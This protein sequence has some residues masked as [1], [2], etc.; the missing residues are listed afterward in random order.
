[1]K[2]IVAMCKKTRGIG[3]RNLLPFN[4]VAD[5]KRF[6]KLTVGKGNNAI[7]MGR[8]TWLSLPKKPLP[9]R[10]NIIISNNLNSSNAIIY[11]DPM[12]IL[13][14]NNKYDDIWIIGG[15][16]LYNFYLKNNLVNDIYLTEIIKTNKKIDY[17]TFFPSIS[18]N[19]HCVSQDSPTYYESEVSGPQLFKYEFKYTKFKLN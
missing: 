2:L 17:D 3:F 8:N 16:Q 1:M 13:K 15:E 12:R 9:N 7:I 4:L 5:M 18:E 6:K 19:F 10:T 14:D 11:N